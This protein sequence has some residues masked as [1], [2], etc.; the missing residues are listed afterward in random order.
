MECPGSVKLSEA[1]PPS[2]SSPEAEEGT[3]AHAM[4]EA[5]LRG[6]LDAWELINDEWTAEMA[7]HVQVY[8]DTVRAQGADQVLVEH[9]IESPE[10][11]GFGGTADC[12][13]VFDN[14][15]VHVID[16]K[17]GAGLPVDVEGNLQLRY[18]A[19]GVLKSLGITKGVV[20]LTIVQ[21]RAEHRDGPVRSESLKVGEV[22]RW[23][24]EE[25]LPS[26]AAVDAD[27]PRL[28][29]GEHC[30]FCPAL[31]VCPLMR[32]EFDDMANGAPAEVE[33]FGDNYLSDQYAKIAQVKMY[34][35]ALEQEAFRRA[36]QGA[37]IEGT[38]LIV[39]RSSREWKDGA[40][41]ALVSALGDDAFTD[42]TLKSPAQ[43]EKLPGG[44]KLAAEW[45]YK[46]DGGPTLVPYDKPGTPYNVADAGAA[47]ASI[48]APDAERNN[49]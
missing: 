31:L 43:V 30:R 44:K 49:D 12:V 41:E 21:P 39:G 13:L 14:G 28:F 45:S 23:G 19:Y 35:R 1:L 37:P 20:T 6:D 10:I 24:D 34:I 2:P 48:V 33:A 40:D 16:L 32:K 5:A 17:Y 42:P 27:D 29:A 22:L 25:L 46:K 18:Y 15:D 11:P 9:R 26:M 36:M 4:A 38:K 7:R 8:L 3:L 47:F